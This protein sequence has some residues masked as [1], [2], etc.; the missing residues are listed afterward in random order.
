MWSP[1]GKE[2]FYR[3]SNKWMVVSISTETE[4]KTESPQVVFEGPYKD[5]AGRSCDIAPNGQRFLVLKPEYDDSQVREL[6]VVT[7]WFEELRRLVPSAE[8]P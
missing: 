2:L 3:S 6:H 7:N 5:V 8:T 4:F 1:D